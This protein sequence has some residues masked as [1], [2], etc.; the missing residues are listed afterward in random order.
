MNNKQTHLKNVRSLFPFAGNK[1]SQ[2]SQLVMYYIPR[3][4]FTT[5]VVFA[6]VVLVRA[7]IVSE[8]NVTVAEAEIF[9]QA[10]L[11][12][13]NGISYYEPKIDR[14]FPGIID[15]SD[16]NKTEKKINEHLYFGEKLGKKVNRVGARITYYLD[17]DLNNTKIYY[18][19]QFFRF[20]EPWEGVKGP[21]GSYISRKQFDTIFRYNNEF[22][23][24]KIKIEVGVPNE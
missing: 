10:L 19:K 20:L 9:G 22:Y 12:S 5:I 8:V 11:Y 3:I 1:K 7:F 14:V 13:K 21:G 15:I 4:F 24:G 23:P 16:L 2:I 18:N 17:N 6:I